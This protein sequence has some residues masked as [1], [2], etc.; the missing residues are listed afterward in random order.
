LTKGSLFLSAGNLHRAAGSSS[1]DN[2]RGMS[3]LTPRS[4]AM[5]VTGMF[6]ITACP[7]FGPFFS[8]L[9]VVRAAIAARHIVATAIFLGCLLLA[10][11]GM[12]RVVFAVVDG[13]P[14]KEAKSSGQRFVETTGVIAPPLLLL[15]LSLW[16]GL[17]TPP[18]LQDAWTAAVNQLFPLP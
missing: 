8:E 10:F 15:G 11:V 14:R 5:F 1:I 17:F 6:A 2:V 12:T 3:V 16:L 18:A 13:R 9:Q 4:A 7:P